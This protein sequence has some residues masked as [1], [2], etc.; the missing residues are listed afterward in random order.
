MIKFKIKG[1]SCDHCVAAVTKVLKN[2]PGTS[3]VVEVSLDRAEA[4]ID[5]TPDTV[6]LMT[7]LKEEGF[8]AELAE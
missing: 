1:M 4:V 7:A 2:A 8:P 5:G 6:A 3:K